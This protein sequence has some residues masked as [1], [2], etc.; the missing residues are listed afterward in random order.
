MLVLRSRCSHGDTV[1]GQQSSSI[2][3][4]T[5]QLLV[6]AGTLLFATTVCKYKWVLHARCGAN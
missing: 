5:T 3:I 6:Q 4:P 1:V 2:S